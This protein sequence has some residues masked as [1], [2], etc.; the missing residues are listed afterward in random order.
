[1]KRTLAF[2]PAA[3]LLH[4]SDKCVA[5][6]YGLLP[7]LLLAGLQHEINADL[8]MLTRSNPRKAQPCSRFCIV[9]H[10]SV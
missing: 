8:R 5:K 9:L 1:M 2:P 10:S 3:L 7:Q 6:P 4:K